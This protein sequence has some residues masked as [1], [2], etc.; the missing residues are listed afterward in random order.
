MHHTDCTALRQCSKLRQLHVSINSVQGQIIQC[1][2][3]KN[4]SSPQFLSPSV[5]SQWP[6]YGRGTGATSK[7]GVTCGRT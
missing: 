1:P 6:E 7:E 4:C 2:V 5:F 3:H